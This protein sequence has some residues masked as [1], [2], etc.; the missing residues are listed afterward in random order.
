MEIR[1]TVV[2]PGVD[3][4]RFSVRPPDPAILERIPDRRGPVVMFVGTL[5][6]FSGLDALLAHWGALERRSPGAMLVIVGD[7]P[8]ARYLRALVSRNQLSER[9]FFAGVRPFD[10]IPAWLSAADIAINPLAVN[11]ITRDIVPIKIFQY[12]ACGKP[13]VSAPFPDLMRLLPSSEAGIVY[14]SSAEPQEVHRYDRGHALG[15]TADRCFGPA[16][17][18]LRGDAVFAGT[19]G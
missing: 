18:E 6:P 15:P 10:E 16:R 11:D 5:Y 4:N 1:T 7:G 13:I 19:R 3:T 9:V 14:R 12:M 8:Q 17:A 2:E